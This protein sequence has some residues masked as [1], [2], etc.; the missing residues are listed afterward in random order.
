MGRAGVF[1]SRRHR[2]RHVFATAALAATVGMTSCASQ[3]VTQ[4]GRGSTDTSEPRDLNLNYKVLGAGRPLVLLHGYGLSTYSWRYLV[5]RLVQSQRYKVYLVDLKGFGKSP[6]PIDGAYS[7]HDQARLI[8]RLMAAERLCDVT[9]IGHS[10]GGGV[11]LVTTLDGMPETPARVTS[12][13]LIDAASYRTPLPLFVRVVRA[14]IIGRIVLL[15]TPAAV[16]AWALLYMSYYDSSRIAQETISTYARTLHGPGSRDALRETL[17]QLPPPDIEQLEARYST[18]AVPTLI[19]WGRHDHVIPLSVGRKLHEVITGSELVIVDDSAHI[20][21][22][23]MP[24]QTVDAIVTFLAAIT[25][26]GPHP[27][28]CP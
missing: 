25:A 7:V 20:S 4:A 11:A 9:L 26:L 6:K 15:L 28:Q 5:D 24:D 2:L 8:A 12:L 21:H 1:T 3:P 19:I 14:P 16:K 10:F 22:E 17:R 13:V 18:I 23:E 27:A